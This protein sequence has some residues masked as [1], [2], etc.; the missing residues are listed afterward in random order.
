MIKV[1]EYIGHPVGKTDQ[2]GYHRQIEIIYDKVPTAQAWMD[3]IKYIEAYDLREK[4]TQTNCRV[5]ECQ[6]Q[7]KGKA[8]SK[9]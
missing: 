5:R 3:F 6:C 8:F 1:N 7:W 2:E 9:L 4:I